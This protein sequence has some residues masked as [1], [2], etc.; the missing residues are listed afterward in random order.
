[1]KFHRAIDGQVSIAHLGNDLTWDFGCLPQIPDM[2]CNVTYVAIWK[3]A[4]LTGKYSFQSTR[5]CCYC[6]FYTWTYSILAF[7]GIKQTCPCL[8][9][10]QTTNKYTSEIRL[11]FRTE[12][13]EKY[14]CLFTAGERIRIHQ[15]QIPRIYWISTFNIAQTLITNIT[16]INN[17]EAMDNKTNYL[18]TLTRSR[19]RTLSA[20]PD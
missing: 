2:P 19:F 12:N 13:T 11:T 16:I 7:Y 8:Y 14:Q 15:R 3:D 20:S 4:K 9:I 1:M 5:F 17:C 10:L 6:K 18:Y